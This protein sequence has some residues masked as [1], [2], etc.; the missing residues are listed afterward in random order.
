MIDEKI[1]AYYRLCAVR[2]GVKS[3]IVTDIPPG[4]LVA[5]MTK[6]ELNL[7]LRERDGC[8]VAREAVVGGG[9]REPILAIY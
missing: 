7:F 2:M 8:Y 3:H 1:V 5:V 9:P 6:K 4:K